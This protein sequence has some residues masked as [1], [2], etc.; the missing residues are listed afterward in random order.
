MYTFILLLKEKPLLMFMISEKTNTFISFIIYECHCLWVSKINF[1]WILC[2]LTCQISFTSKKWSMNYIWRCLNNHPPKWIFKD[3]AK[4]KLFNDLPRKYVIKSKT[5]HLQQQYA[6]DL[7]CHIL[8]FLG[9]YW[10]WTL[11]NCILVR[12]S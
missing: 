8:I 5:N 7:N 1:L 11:G 6:I 3:K 4:K 10:K 2:N 9:L 12:I